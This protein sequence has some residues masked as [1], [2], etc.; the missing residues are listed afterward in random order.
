MGFRNRSQ[1]LILRCHTRNRRQPGLVPRSALRNKNPLKTQSSSP[2]S[3]PKPVHKLHKTHTTLC[4]TRS[5]ASPGTCHV[6]Q[7]HQKLFRQCLWLCPH[8]LGGACIAARLMSSSTSASR[9]QQNSKP[10][11]TLRTALNA[12]PSG[13]PTGQPAAASHPSKINFN[14]S[15]TL[16][17]R[18]RDR[19]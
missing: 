3:A 1:P 17:G 13:I 18:C 11:S 10:Q 8:R 14:F 5:T 6:R 12:P 9:W 4:R 2:L 15:K 19:P 16:V 7:P